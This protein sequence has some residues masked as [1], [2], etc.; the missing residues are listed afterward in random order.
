MNSGLLAL[1]VVVLA[2]IAPCSRLT[3]ADID[4][5]APV[6]EDEKR[7]LAAV[8]EHVQQLTM[9]STGPN[10]LPVAVVEQPLLSFGDSARLH[11][12]GT[13]WAGETRGG[14]WRSWRSGEKRGR[15]QFGSIQSHLPQPSELC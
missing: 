11:S 6:A 7:E 4:S 13:L 8:L 14:P 3:Y 2:L 1:T 9:V 5:R 10:S 15:L 12:S